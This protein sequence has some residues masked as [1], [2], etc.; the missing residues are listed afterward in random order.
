MNAA[1][2]LV[3]GDKVSNLKEGTQ[4]AQEVIDNGQAMEKLNALVKLS[5]SLN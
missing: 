1:A 2:A 5:Q 4:L 3:A